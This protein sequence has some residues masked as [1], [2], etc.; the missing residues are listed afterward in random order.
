MK[1]RFSISFFVHI[2]F[3]LTRL[4]RLN[5]MF[6]S[7][8]IPSDFEIFGKKWFLYKHK[9]K[10]VSDGSSMPHDSRIAC[11]YDTST[12]H[13]SWNEMNFFW[14]FPFFCPVKNKEEWKYLLKMI[15]LFFVCC[16][17]D[18]RVVQIFF[19]LTSAIKSGYANVIAYFDVEN[20]SLCL[21]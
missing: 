3:T 17:V 9:K 16:V 5:E 1:R 14:V 19:S 6:S 20:V 12:R 21:Q 15:A 8:L 13:M 18:V 2:S 10:K 11:T 4:S 7:R